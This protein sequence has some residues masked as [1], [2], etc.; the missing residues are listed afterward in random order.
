[1]VTDFICSEA[2]LFFFSWNLFAF[3]LYSRL[4]SFPFNS[5]L[6]VFLMRFSILQFFFCIL[7]F[8]EL[9]FLKI[10]EFLNDSFISS[11]KDKYWKWYCNFKSIRNIRS[12]KFEMKYCFPGKF[13]DWSLNHKPSIKFSNILNL[14]LT[15]KSIYLLRFND[16]YNTSGF[17]QIKHLFSL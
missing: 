1:M 2:K 12:L 6:T 9:G 13:I 16:R 17:I 8:K 4:K 15:S 10:V 3:Y 14:I 7:S 5:I 11:M